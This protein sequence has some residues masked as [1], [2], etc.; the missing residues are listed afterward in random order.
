MKWLFLS[1][2][3]VFIQKDKEVIWRYGQTYKE[4]YC[5]DQLI[6]YTDH[7]LIYHMGCESRNSLRFGTWKQVGDSVQINYADTSGIELVR[8]VNIKKSNKSTD[9]V[10]IHV[11]DRYNR[12]IEEAY[13]LSFPKGMSK[14]S[15]LRINDILDK[16]R[17]LPFLYIEHFFE[18]DSLLKMNVYESSA[19]GTFTVKK[20]DAD[21]IMLFL[22]NQL[23]FKRIIYDLSG[24]QSEIKIRMNVPAETFGYSGNK[25][26]AYRLQDKFKISDLKEPQ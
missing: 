5:S 21:S 3:L 15:Q 9:S 2:I 26:I 14:K 19:K 6:F 13:F 18:G 24:S 8:S 4:D 17:R 16:T 23:S 22:S 7:F 25:W 1:L 12:P 10:I 20:A 11:T